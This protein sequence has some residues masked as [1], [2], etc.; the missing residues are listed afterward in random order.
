MGCDNCRCS[1]TEEEKEERL[2][3]EE[4]DRQRKLDEAWDNPD[5]HYNGS[6]AKQTA[7]DNH[8]HTGGW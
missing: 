1:E 4:R 7:R 2:D 6:H 5:P 3:Q 8:L